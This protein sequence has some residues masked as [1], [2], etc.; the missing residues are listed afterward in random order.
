MVWYRLTDR[1]FGSHRSS[2]VHLIA[3]IQIV[4]AINGVLFSPALVADWSVFGTITT[5]WS[6]RSESL[7]GPLP[8]QIN[9]RII[10]LVLESRK[11]AKFDERQPSNGGRSKEWMRK[12]WCS[13]PVRTRQ[14]RRCLMA[15]ETERDEMDDWRQHSAIFFS[16]WKCLHQ[17]I[18][19]D[20]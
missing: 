13:P 20:I 15:R 5:A 3:Q 12:S 9:I 14:D 16:R 10:E 17:W 11:A 4:F 7:T 8:L 18:F 2:S 19:T 1:L 6:E